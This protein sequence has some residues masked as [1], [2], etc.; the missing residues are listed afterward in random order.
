MKNL[1]IGKKLGLAFVILL[2]ITA[3]SSFYVLF[4]LKKSSQQSHDLFRGPY[5]VTNNAL[6]VRRDSFD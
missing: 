1:K 5:Q 2:V 3:F 6:G 4:N